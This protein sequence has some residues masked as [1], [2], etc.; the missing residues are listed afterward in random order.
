MLLFLSLSVDI[1]TNPGPGRSVST[2]TPETRYTDNLFSFCNWN[3][4]TLSKNEFQ[5]VSIL[6]AHNTHFKYDIISLCE[7][8]RKMETKGAS[9]DE[10]T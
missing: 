1:E 8:K 3:L 7:T 4:N 6:E 9:N 2:G 5:R 10:G